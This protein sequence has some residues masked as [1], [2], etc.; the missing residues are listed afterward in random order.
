MNTELNDLIRAWSDEVDA[1][2]VVFMKRDGMSPTDANDMARAVVNAR[3]KL[4][5]EGRKLHPKEGGE[6]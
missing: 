3:R 5:A 1:E 2:A 4:A 6:S